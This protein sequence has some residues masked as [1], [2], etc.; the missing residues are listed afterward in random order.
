LTQAVFNN[1]NLELASFDRT[2]LEKADFRSSYNYVINPET[3]KIKKA[4]FSLLGVAGL[5][6]KYDIV[7]EK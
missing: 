2:L 6:E 7:I 3:N 4:K 5:L 1:C